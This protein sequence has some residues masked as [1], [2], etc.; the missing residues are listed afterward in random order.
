M[1][2]LHQACSK[3]SLLLILPC[4]WR[5]T[6]SGR[7]RNTKPGKKLSVGFVSRV[8]NGRDN[9]APKIREVMTHRK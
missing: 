5:Y 6:W 4:V 1:P 8:F 9:V 7:V 2:R 3:I